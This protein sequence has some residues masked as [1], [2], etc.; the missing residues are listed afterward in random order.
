MHK[1]KEDE[2]KSLINRGRDIECYIN[3]RILNEGFSIKISEY[4]WFWY[5]Y[6]LFADNIRL[7]KSCLI[8]LEE[9]VEWEAFILARSQFN[10]T[11]WVNYLC[12]TDKE[13]RADEYFF[14]QYIDRLI[15]LKKNK[16]YVT[17]C[18]LANKDAIDGEITEIEDILREHGYD[19]EFINKIGKGKG[20]KSI[21][22]LA[23]ETDL[24]K[25]YITYYNEGSRYEHSSFRGKIKNIRVITNE[26]SPDIYI[27]EPNNFDSE[28]WKKVFVFSL[29]NIF[30][31]LDAIKTSLSEMKLFGLIDL[32]EKDLE[33]TMCKIYELKNQLTD[34]QM[35]E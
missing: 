15:T 32:S 18:R 33:V 2:I 24:L 11:L 22:K 31:T 12:G 14:Q 28:L 17:T 21:Y 23:E 9:K 34:K 1:L 19:D 5:A 8:L 29:T 35:L 3:E 20:T 25:I 27:Y 13:K 16:E 26:S 6:I 4:K 30:Y 10:N 7:F